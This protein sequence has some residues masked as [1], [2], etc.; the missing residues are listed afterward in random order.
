M[1]ADHDAIRAPWR[2]YNDGTGI[3]DANDRHVASVG[4]RAEAE[5]LLDAL[6]LARHDGYIKGHHD[7]YQGSRGD[8]AEL[9]ADVASATAEIV[10]LTADRAALADEVARQGEENANMRG[11]L[12]ILYEGNRVTLNDLAAARAEVE[13]L[14]G[15]LE[16]D[17]KANGEY[18]W[19]TASKVTALKLE[20][21][22]ERARVAELERQLAEAE[23]QAALVCSGCEHP[24]QVHLPDG[25]GAGGVIW[26]GDCPCPAVYPAADIADAS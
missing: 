12:E 21:K 8:I 7:G 6:L 2:I 19:G 16:A 9:K 5:R 17:R 15:E 11:E 14:K 10:E 4:N 3:A 1:T 18:L 13:K 22:A 25:C 23:F 24:Q 26:G 20:V